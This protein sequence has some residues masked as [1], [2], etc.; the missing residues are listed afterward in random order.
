MVRAS[1]SSQHTTE[2]TETGGFPPYLEDRRE[3]TIVVSAKRSSTSDGQRAILAEREPNPDTPCDGLF[4]FAHAF[5]VTLLLDDFRVLLHVLR[6]RKVI[7][8]ASIV[9]ARELRHI[10]RVDGA[11]VVPMNALKEGMF[12]HLGKSRVANARVSDQPR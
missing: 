4:L 12:T 5:D 7:V 1:P 3:C 11:E 6:G 9:L 8:I 2:R 10:W